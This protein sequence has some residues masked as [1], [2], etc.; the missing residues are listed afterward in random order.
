M[1]RRKGPRTWITDSTT[2][3]LRK[4]FDQELNSSL[5]FHVSTE[6]PSNHTYVPRGLRDELITWAH[7]QHQPSDTL[8]L[9]QAKY[10]RPSMAKEV[11]QN[12]QSSSICAQPKVSSSFSCWEVITSSHSTMPLLTH[13]PRLSH[14]STRVRRKCCHNVHHRAIF[15]DHSNSFHFLLKLFI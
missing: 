12:V 11:H 2:S 15:L 9:I 13:R 10:R 3:M 4:S 8:V 1:N 5:L 6:C 7:T 14:R